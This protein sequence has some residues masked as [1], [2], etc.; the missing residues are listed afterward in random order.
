MIPIAINQL[1]T[2]L[3]EASLRRAEE[4]DVEAV[5]G[6]SG[7]ARA[8]RTAARR[9]VADMISL[10]ATALV[11]HTAEEAHGSI[12]AELS[13]RGLRVPEDISVV[14]VGAGVSVVGAAARTRKVQD[15]DTTCPS[16]D[17]AR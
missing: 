16:A 5:H 2:Y 4:R 8:S 17:V 1:R 3:R 15:P 11:L 13:E 14:S 10:G 7:G 6:T 12:L 9:T